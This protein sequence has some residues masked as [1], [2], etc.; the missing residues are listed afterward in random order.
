MK[1]TRIKPSTGQESVWDYPRPPRVED[2]TKHIK[3][4]FNNLII[5]D[6]RNVKRVLEKSSPPI[7]Y[8][9]L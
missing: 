2:S 6:T 5:A 4:V 3:V 1:P 9:Q 7:Y 8:I